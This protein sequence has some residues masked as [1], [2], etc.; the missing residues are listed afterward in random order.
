MS[1]FDLIFQGAVNGYR[2]VVV[3]LRVLT[4]TAE[5]LK[6]P[7]L[8]HSLFTIHTS[9]LRGVVQD[10]LPSIHC[11]GDDNQIYVSFSSADETGHPDAIAAFEG[12]IQVI[13]NWMHV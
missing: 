6:V 8:D 7:F 2:F 3:S 12:Y 9:S 11:Y 5:F 4:R 13:R 10:Y 1:G